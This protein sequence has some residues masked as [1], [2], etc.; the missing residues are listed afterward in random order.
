MSEPPK[1]HTW[2]TYLFYKLLFSLPFSFFSY[3]RGLTRPSHPHT[4]LHIPSRDPNRTILAHV[5]APP[6]PS[7]P[8]PILLNFHGSGFMIPM[9]GT[10]SLF[11]HR[12]AHEA[13]YTVIDCSYRLAPDHPFPCPVED[14]EDALAY[15][16]AHP[17]RYDLSHLALSGFSAGANLALV[18][19]HQSS[20]RYPKAALGNVRLIAFYP[21]TD[22]SIAAESKKTPDGKA[23]TLPAG[24]MKAFNA[25]YVLPGQDI[26]DPRISPGRAA[27]GDFPAGMESLWVTG[28]KDSLLAEAEEM[29]GRLEGSGRRATVKRVVGGDH[30]FD[31]KTEGKI[32]AEERE[33]KEESYR[34]AVEFLK[35]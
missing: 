31:K 21:P 16:L 11:C 34:M 29:A 22:L 3:F 1:A 8:S 26:G 28:T 13:G 35:L 12:V 10:D 33:G 9:H 23:G 27:V 24:I 25:A 5:Y 6:S 19:A 17:D 32:T 2:P 7:S 18:L 20:A 30:G 4:L 14:A 15:V